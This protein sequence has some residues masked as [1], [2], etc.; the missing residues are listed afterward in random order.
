MLKR[1][2]LSA[3]SA[4]LLWQVAPASAQDL[5]EI[6]VIMPLPRS[7]NFYPLLAGE[8]LGYFEDEGL[9]VNLLPSETTVPYVAFLTNGQTEIAVLDGPQTFQA[10]QAELPIKVI[11]EAMQ[12][13]PEGVVVAADSPIQSVEELE[14]KMVG[15]VSDR[16]RATLAITLDLV[17]KNIDDVE[18][19]VVGEAGPTLANAFRNQTVAA[20]AGATPDWI[21]LQANGIEIRDITPPEMA[22]TPANSFV[23]NEERE[24]ALRDVLE[25]FVRAWS[26]GIYVAEIDREALAA[27]A[28]KAVPEE[29]QDEDFGNLFLDMSIPLNYSV[30]EQFGALRPDV[31]QL[32]QD[33]MIKVG[34]IKQE[35]DVDAFLDPSFIGPANDFDK[36]EVAAD[37]ERWK[38]ENM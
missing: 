26:K 11:Y 9:E 1:T 18:T 10:V 17:G 15:L 4:I 22:E 30:T 37:V 31:W 19:V 3:L 29:W 7:T 28:K 36:A 23:I 20:I 5:Q 21:A 12:R 33:Q 16:D 6:N 2:V 24:D 38:Q 14:G 8:A 27:M 25:G 13:A 34:E 32:V 35:Y